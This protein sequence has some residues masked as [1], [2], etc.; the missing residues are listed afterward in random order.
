[1]LLAPWGLDLARR[2]W[3][4]RD[5]TALAV[6]VAPPCAAIVHA[7]YVVRVGGDFMHGRLLLP[8]L[9]AF[10]LP[11]ATVY[12]KP[13]TAA[14]WRALGLAALAG[15]ALLC[16]L[17]LRVPYPGA[18]GPWAIADERGFYARYRSDRHLIELSDYAGLAWMD[19]GFSMQHREGVLVID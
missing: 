12:V 16:A 8:D 11:V 6:I 19:L 15:W 9:F 5:A 13:G 17:F 7:L 10:L 4:R 2:A 14:R 18:I 1:L 3:R